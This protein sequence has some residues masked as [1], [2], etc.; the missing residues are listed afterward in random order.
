MAA[1]NGKVYLVGAGPGDPK[2]ITLKGIECLQRA[3]GV[4]AR[5]EDNRLHLIATVCSPDGKHRILERL[6]GCYE[7]R[8][9]RGNSECAQE[10]AVNLATKLIQSGAH[11][12]QS[13]T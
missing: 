3:I 1:I 5:L 13:G 6:S 10:L 7:S 11:K 8:P 4:N 2:L 9:D 12:L